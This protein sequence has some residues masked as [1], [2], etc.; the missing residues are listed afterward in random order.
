MRRKSN[1]QNFGKVKKQNWLRGRKYDL[2]HDHGKPYDPENNKPEK[3]ILSKSDADK[4]HTY[5]KNNSKFKDFMHCMEK[6]GKFIFKSSIEDI[7]IQANKIKPD[8]CRGIRFY[9]GLEKYKTYSV[10]QK[11]ETK[12]EIRV[13]LVGVDEF[14]NNIDEVW[15]EDSFEE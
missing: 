8:L 1:D 7:F 13:I 3:Q 6:S 12:Y 11:K 14:G 10:D 2:I 5:F 4:F 9:Y 15:K